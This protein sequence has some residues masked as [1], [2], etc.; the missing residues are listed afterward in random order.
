MTSVEMSAFDLFSIGHSNI[1]ADRFVALL[2]DAGV[3]AV[4]DVRSTLYSRVFPWFSRKPLEKCLAAAGIA[5]VSYGCSLG[6]RPRGQNLYRDGVVDYDAMARSAE[7]QDGLEGLQSDAGGRRVCLM[8]AEREPLDCHRC[9]LVARALSERGLTVG[10][11]LHDGTIEAHAAA[12]QRLMDWS[13]AGDDLFVTGQTQRLAAAYQR[14]ARAV[15]FRVKS[16]RVAASGAKPIAE[17][18]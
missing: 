14:R 1:P 8:C 12:E 11:I 13:A 3:T 6:G 2:R 9:L 15:A 4:A 18:R 17:R 16:S 10:H 7:F 5:Y